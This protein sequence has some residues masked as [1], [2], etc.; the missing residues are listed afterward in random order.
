MQ[1]R[2]HVLYA[3]RAVPDFERLP[4][5]RVQFFQRLLEGLCEDF[6]RDF[7]E[8]C[9]LPTMH[10]RNFLHR[11]DQWVRSPFQ[12]SQMTHVHLL[13]CAQPAAE[14][15]RC[16]VEGTLLDQSYN[17]RLCAAGHALAQSKRVGL[18]QHCREGRKYDSSY[19]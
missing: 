15:H 1:T 17:G 18:E 14:Q 8:T 9:D 4:P 10:G 19:K 7:M 16:A 11:S 5:T 12:A 2:V 6:R 13:S 3:C